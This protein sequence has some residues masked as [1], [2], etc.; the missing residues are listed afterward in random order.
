MASPDSEGAFDIVVVGA[1]LMGSSAAYYA[2]KTGKRV[3]LLEQFELLHG[4]GSSHGNS[5]IFRV[6]YPNAVYTTLCLESLDLWH[7]IEKE[8][9]ADVKLIEMTGEL[10]FALTRNAD[11]TKLE[12]VLAQHDLAFDTMTGAEANARFPGFSLDATSHAVFNKYA[13]VLNPHLAMA[14]LQKLAQQHGAVIRANS[15]VVGIFAADDKDGVTVVELADGTSISV[16]Q[17]IVTS[18]AWTT[19]L[20]KHA[21]S[22]SLKIQPIATYGTYWKPH[23]EELYK[24]ANFP[25]FINYGEDWI[26]GIPMTD[27]TEGVKICRHDGPPVDPDA[28]AGVEQP[29]DHTERLRAYVAK[30]FSQVDAS[31]P[32]K[33]DHC[34]Y[35]MTA[36]ENFIIDFLSVAART[37]AAK[38]TSVVV[39]AGFS[40]HG[41]KMTPVIGKILAELAIHGKTDHNIDLFHAD[42]AEVKAVL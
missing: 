2:S 24:P 5:R 28:R 34:M 35:S 15:K 36:D 40:G 12:E 42:R 6:A 20:L 33:T 22:H 27:P 25:V 23:N 1:G 13:G 16:R 8:A 37:D 7:A 26:Y 19:S 18:G 29:V 41:A 14:T 30:N 21:S 9:G 3:L 31:G 10:D 32:A 38:T 17:C 39:G 4:H 11:L